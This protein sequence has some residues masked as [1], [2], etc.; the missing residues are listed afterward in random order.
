MKMKGSFGGATNRVTEESL[1]SPSTHR[2]Q[3]VT[4]EGLTTTRGKGIAST[5]SEQICSRKKQN[6][7]NQNQSLVIMKHLV[8]SI[9]SL[10]AIALLAI[11]VGCAGD[12]QEKENLTIAAGF[13]VI[14]PSKPDQVALLP[15]LPANKVTRVTYAGK[16]YYILPDLKHNQ[17]YVGGP[18]QYKAYQQLRLAKQLSNEN[19]EAAQMNEMASTTWGGWG[20]WGAGWG[21]N[22]W[23]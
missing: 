21:G 6:P 18:K 5:P 4:G 20:G 17:A 12:L 19:L 9:K 23:Y 3:I 13:K 22:D 7:T 15:T 14:T 1:N 16:T 8:T 11:G 2:N 10:G